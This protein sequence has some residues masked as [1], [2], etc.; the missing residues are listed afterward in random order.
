MQFLATEFLEKK[1]SVYKTAT[2]IKSKTPYYRLPYK[3]MPRKRVNMLLWS[4]KRIHL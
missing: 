2:F 3:L 1:S 4:F